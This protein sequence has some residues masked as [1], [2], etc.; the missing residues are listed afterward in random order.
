MSGQ[1]MAFAV[2]IPDAREL[3]VYRRPGPLPR[4]GERYDGMMV[5]AVWPGLESDDPTRLKPF[6]W[7]S[8]IQRVTCADEGVRPVSTRSWFAGM[9]RLE[10]VDIGRM[11]MGRVRDAGHMFDGCATL[12]LDC[13]R[14]AFPAGALHD[15]FS[16]DAPGVLPPAVWKDIERATPKPKTKPEPAADGARRHGGRPTPDPTPMLEWVRSRRA[17]G[18]PVSARL[19]YEAGL[20]SSLSSAA[21]IYRRVRDSHPELFPAQ[22]DRR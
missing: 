12:R 8:D 5:D 6:L 17:G 7:L 21:R 4:P 2:H 13:T 18:E 9:T 11:D 15:G 1:T 10:S 14:C 3:R 20:A 22:A 16:T 19:A